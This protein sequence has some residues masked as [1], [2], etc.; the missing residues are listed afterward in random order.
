MSNNNLDIPSILSQLFLNNAP[1]NDDKKKVEDTANI[2]ANITTLQ[3][4]INLVNEGK[5]IGSKRLI[6]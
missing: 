4:Y 2:L 1:T 3:E 6:E 5:I